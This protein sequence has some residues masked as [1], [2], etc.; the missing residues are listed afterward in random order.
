M[1][2]GAPRMQSRRLSRFGPHA[3][4]IIGGVVEE[5]R[6]ELGRWCRKQRWLRPPSDDTILQG[7]VQ[8]YGM[9][10]LAAPGTSGFNSVAWLVPFIALGLRPSIPCGNRA[11]MEVPSRTRFGRWHRSYS[12]PGTRTLPT[13]GTKGD[14][15]MSDQNILI[16][17]VFSANR[18]RLYYIFYLPNTGSLGPVKDT[19]CLS[20]RAPR[21]RIRQ[22]R[23]LNF[24]YKAGKVPDADYTS[25]K[26]S[27][28]E[29]AAAILSEIS[30]L[31]SAP[32]SS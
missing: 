2:S 18:R 28:E 16:L 20:A 13:T 7:F 15:T 25:M 8:K 14:G 10:V 22:L 3:K 9:T 1:Q 26:L 19:S 12:R 17:C 32:A 31:E 11:R 21:S 23:D 24:E 29:E 5:R 6:R 30:K 4:R 27:L